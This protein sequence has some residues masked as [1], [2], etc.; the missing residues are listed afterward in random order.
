MEV[1][2]DHV[3]KVPEPPSRRA[4]VNVPESLS[5]IAL[6]CLEKDPRDRYQTFDELEAALDAASISPEW[7]QHRARAW[8]AAHPVEACRLEQTDELAIAGRAAG[9]P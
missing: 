9:G 2:M 6:K 4:I 7:N 3:K 1:I 5:L 8:W